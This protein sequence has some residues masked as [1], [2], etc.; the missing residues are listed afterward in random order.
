MAVA[1]KVM[2]CAVRT[3]FPLMLKLAW[4]ADCWGLVKNSVMAVALA[5]FVVKVG[6]FQADSIV[7]GT[8]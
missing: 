8:E 2:P 1:V 4:R 5:S 7:R 6:R 3:L